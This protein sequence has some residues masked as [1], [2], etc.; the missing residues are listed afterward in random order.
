[1]S[2]SSIAIVRRVPEAVA[3]RARREFDAL[4]ANEDL[5]TDAALRAAE[6]HRAEALVIGP[7]IRLDAAGIA[8]LPDHVRIVATTSV[9]FDHIDTAAARARGLVVTNTPDVLTDCTADLAFM[10]ILC[11]C[12]RASEYDRIMRQGWRRSFGLPD[13]LGLQP[14]GRTLGIIGMGRIGRAVAERAQGFRMR[15]LYSNRT[16]LPPELE[17]G[18]EYFADWRAMLPHCQILSL[19]LPGGPGSDGMMDREAFALLPRGAV[20][21]NAARGALVDEDALIE[22]LTSGQL[23]AAG[24]DVYRREPDFDTRLAELP[25]VFLTPHVAS[26]TI[27]TRNAMGFRALDNVAAVLAGRPPLDPV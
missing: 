4:L 14:S 5:D 16:R 11:A 13:M 9:G 15:V 27:E 20:F 8:R 18:A 21:V 12:R 22:A 2:G 1:M 24:L 26:A 19:H 10:L 17:A 25:N 23:F 3:Q 7:R 6:G